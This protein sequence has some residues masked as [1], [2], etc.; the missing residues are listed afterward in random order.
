VDGKGMGR[1]ISL[2]DAD[3]VPDGRAIDERRRLCTVSGARGNGLEGGAP[4]TILSSPSGFWEAPPD[5]L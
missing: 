2:L 3:D 1:H 5:R 4:I